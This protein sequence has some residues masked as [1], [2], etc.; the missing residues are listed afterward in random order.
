MSVT[1]HN[2]APDPPKPEVPADFGQ[3]MWFSYM[4]IFVVFGTV[5][6]VDNQ[7]FLEMWD[8]TNAVRAGSVHL[9]LFIVRIMFFA[10]LLIWTYRW[11]DATSVEAEYWVAWL[12]YNQ[13][14]REAFRAMCALA[15]FLGLM[16]AFADRVVVVTCFFTVCLLLN[17]YTQWFC[18]NEVAKALVTARG[19]HA[20]DM[21]RMKILGVMEHFWIGRPQLGRITIMMFVSSM[22][23]ALALAGAV[24]PQPQRDYFQVAAYTVLMALI[25]VSEVVIFF[26][27]RR[28]DHDIE[29][30]CS[31]N[32]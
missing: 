26:W 8:W 15:L 10:Q 9:V 27:R 20:G 11:I 25:I 13:K 18:N 28:L 19:R 32:T 1:A 22:A 6:A 12:D 31:S 23:F 4:G 2:V 3:K 24:Q 14:P 17:Y 5:L 30:A 21:T 16:L 29:E 7:K